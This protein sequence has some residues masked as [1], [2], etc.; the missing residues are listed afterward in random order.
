MAVGGRGEGGGGTLSW[1]K[2]SAYYVSTSHQL[3][4][5]KLGEEEG[6]GTLTVLYSYVCNEQN[7]SDW[8]KAVLFVSELIDDAYSIFLCRGSY[9]LVWHGCV[10]MRRRVR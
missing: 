5:L 8:R 6:R 7:L 2:Y 3:S 1:Y 10:W 9:K 4:A